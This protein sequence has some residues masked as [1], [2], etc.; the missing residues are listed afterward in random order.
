MNTEI[1]HTNGVDLA[2][3]MQ[4]ES[5]QNAANRGT[6][7]AALVERLERLHPDFRVL[8]GPYVVSLAQRYSAIQRAEQAA[9]ARALRDQQRAGC[10]AKIVMV[11]AVAFVLRS[12]EGWRCKEDVFSDEIRSVNTR[13]GGHKE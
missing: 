2:R 11:G 3:L 6:T 8:A 10:E 7:G 1:S 12:R 4:L 5:A 13:R 9:C